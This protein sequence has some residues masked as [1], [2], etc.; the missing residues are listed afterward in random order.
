MENNIDIRALTLVSSCGCNLHCK[1]CMINNSL[2]DC[3]A[4]LQQ[5]TINALSD[6]TFL[7]N[8]KKI[9]KRLNIDRY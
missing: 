1:Y 6:G 7:E 4:K 5:D 2:N 8:V 3:S 9:F